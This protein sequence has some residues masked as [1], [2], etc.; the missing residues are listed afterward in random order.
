MKLSVLDRL[1]IL[2]CL[3]EQGTYLTLKI[4]RE[5]RES[6]SFTEEE[7]SEFEIKQAGDAI[8]WNPSKDTGK[9]VDI[10]PAA[11]VIVAD[12]LKKLDKEGKLTSRHMGLYEQ[13]IAVE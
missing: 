5:M 8:N 6:L 7:L 9:E 2:G 1:T 11:H 13:F 4:V 10:G 3:P 12:A